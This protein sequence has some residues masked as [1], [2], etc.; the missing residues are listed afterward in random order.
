MR[1][2]VK[3][4]GL[5]F[6]GQWKMADVREFES[7]YCKKGAHPNTRRSRNGQTLVLLLMAIVYVSSQVRSDTSYFVKT[8]R[9]V[10]MKNNNNETHPTSVPSAVPR[11]RRM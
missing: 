3:L 1:D 7:V 10:S 2:I 11:R 9:H 6:I 8:K 4:L 5:R